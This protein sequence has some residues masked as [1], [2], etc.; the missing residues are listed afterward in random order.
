MPV[1]GGGGG[2]GGVPGGLCLLRKKD[3]PK[4]KAPVKIADQSI[5]DLLGGV[6]WPM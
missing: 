6:V 3:S 1:A 5:F 2:G 4:L